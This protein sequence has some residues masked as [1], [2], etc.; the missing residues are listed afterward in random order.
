MIKITINGNEI[1]A[2]DVT[3]SADIVKIITSCRD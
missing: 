3:L 1:K 2:E